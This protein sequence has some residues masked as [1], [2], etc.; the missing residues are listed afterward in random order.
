MPVSNTPHSPWFLE[1]TNQPSINLPD[2]NISFHWNPTTRGLLCLASFTQLIS[3]VH[4]CHSIYWYLIPFFGQTLHSI[5][6][7]HLI[8]SLIN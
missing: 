3:K 2:V 7:A 1:L 6:I 5:N 4:P 8:Y